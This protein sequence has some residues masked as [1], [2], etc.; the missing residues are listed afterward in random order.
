MDKFEPVAGAAASAAGGGPGGELGEEDRSPSGLLG[1]GGH[2]AAQPVALAV[3][4]ERGEGVGDY[5]QK[6]QQPVP[7][8][9]DYT[10][11]RARTKYGDDR[12]MANN[13]HTKEQHSGN[14]EHLAASWPARQTGRLRQLRQLRRGG[15]E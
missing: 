1:R 7:D 2:P 14:E 4:H 6:D 5:R 11:G 13:E 15:A 12:D 10:C 9:D 8:D 3:L